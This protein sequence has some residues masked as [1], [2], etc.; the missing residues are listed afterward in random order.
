MRH[1]MGGRALDAF[2]LV[3]A[4]AL[5][6]SPALGA[7][8]EQGLAGLS[9]GYKELRQAKSGNRTF[10]LQRGSRNV[11]DRGGLVR[12]MEAGR[13]SPQ[14]EGWHFEAS[15]Q[16]NLFAKG[17][18]TFGAPTGE[19]TM[20]HPTAAAVKG[21][22]RPRKVKAGQLIGIVVRSGFP[23][24]STGGR[25]GIRKVAEQNAQEPG[26]D[27]GSRKYYSQGIALGSKGGGPHVHL[28]HVGH[29]VKPGQVVNVTVKTRDG[30][31]SWPLQ[32]VE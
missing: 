25:G 32:I 5:V 29:D 27:W 26:S 19:V 24:L 17:N 2:V 22:A 6:G 13:L 31:A 14:G 4:I 7:K 9:T 12:T 18:E 28:Y 8:E 21:T 20:L 11:G 3:A 23:L 10:V 30:Q 1:R 16:S 15:Y